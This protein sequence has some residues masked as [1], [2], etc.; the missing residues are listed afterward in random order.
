MRVVHIS[1]IHRSLDV[2]IFYKECR[3]LAA[4]GYEVHLLV[5]NPP[6]T[7]VDGVFFHGIDKVT[8]LPRLHRTWRRLRSTYELATALE[9]DIYHFHDP[10]L[11]P[12]GILLQHLGAKV[13]YDV[14]EDTAW[15][16]ISLHK[17]YP[18]VGWL[19]FGI[20]TL[21]EGVAKIVLDGFICV[22]PKIAGKFPPAKTAVVR[23][24]PLTAELQQTQNSYTPYCARQ[25]KVIYAGGI[26]EIRGIKE[27]VQGM[28]M[29]PTTLGAKLILL[30]EFA[31][32]ELQ[33]QVAQ[34]PGWKSVEFLGWQSRNDV[35]QCLTQGKLGLVIF[36]PQRDHLQA[37]PN[38]LF[39]YMAAGI[40]IVVS[41]FPLWR[42]LVEEIGCG[43]LV[44]P[45]KPQEIA[46]A[47]QY[48]LEHPEA[49]E[50]MGKRG[51]KA[52]MS[53]YN[54]EIESDKLLK[55]YHQLQS[56]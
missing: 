7:E 19:K 28:E 54:W 32:A 37:L 2:R 8:D 42:K 9:A 43:L 17:R 30:G 22:T 34:M 5:P 50:A 49:A 35:V 39:E 12:V 26:T 18:W 13:I 10:E 6:D 51:Q 53:Q 31:P 47:I 38:K 11:I 4:A 41:D 33:N 21:L 27:I 44:N 25:N 3:T 48:I 55:L 24:F 40:P 52:V 56:R 16:A 45:L 20:W 46:Q 36:Y 15:E 14:H 23:N 29:L 1:T